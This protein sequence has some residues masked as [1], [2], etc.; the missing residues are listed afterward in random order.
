MSRKIEAVKGMKLSKKEEE[1]E[2]ESEESEEEEEADKEGADEEEDELPPHEMK[3]VEALLGVHK[4]MDEMKAE[5]AKERIALE[6]KYDALRTPFFEQRRDIILGETAV[7]GGD[8]PEGTPKGLSD[9]W[10]KAIANHPNI[11]QEITAEDIPALRALQ[12]ITVSHNEE[13]TSFTLNFQFASNPYFTNTVLSKTYELTPNLIDENPV[14]GDISGADISWNAGMNL[15]AKETKKKVKAKSGKSKGQVKTITTLEY[16]PSFFHY[17]SKPKKEDEED[18]A[19]EKDEEKLNKFEVSQ[20]ADCEI[21]MAF[22]SEVIPAAINWFTGEAAS[23]YDFGYDDDEDEE[24]DGDEDNEG[25][26]EDDDDDDDAP[27]AKGPKGK[28]AQA[29]GFAGA[30]AGAAGQKPAECKQN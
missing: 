17:F 16:T 12:D 23:E 4:S 21:G 1:E 13:Y 8:A 5:Y 30:G 3:I 19:E 6:K 7:E 9:F 11:S 22:R 14:I 25:D 26:D 28:K 29:Q 27:P 18:D 15:C 24:D 2:S 10:F 20:E